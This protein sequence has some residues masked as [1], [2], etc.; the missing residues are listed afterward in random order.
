MLEYKCVYIAPLE[1]DDPHVG[2][3]IR[4]CLEKELMR[5]RIRIEPGY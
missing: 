5:Q 4:D 2:K 3:V 1:N